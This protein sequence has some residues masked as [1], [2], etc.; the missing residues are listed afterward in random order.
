MML[1]FRFETANFA[2]SKKIYQ[3]KISKLST[4]KSN[5]FT[6]FLAYSNLCSHQ[7]RPT[8]LDLVPQCRQPLT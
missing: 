1:I 2:N 7:I 3:I 5:E 4:M 6:C 8:C